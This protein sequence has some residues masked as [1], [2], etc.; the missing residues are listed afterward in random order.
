MGE[1]VTS[2]K[3]GDRIAAIAELTKLGGYAE[4][5]VVRESRANVVPDAVD[6]P[7]C[8]RSA[9]AFRHG[10][11]DG[12]RVRAAGGRERPGDGGH[13][14]ALHVHHPAGDGGRGPE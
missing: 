11:L 7:D 14:R 1:G 5:V 10:P 6:I 9:A 13:G 12:C 8:D 4:L 2:L 3:A